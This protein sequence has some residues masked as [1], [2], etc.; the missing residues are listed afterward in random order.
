MVERRKALVLLVEDA[1]MLKGSFFGVLACCKGWKMVI[2]GFRS[3]VLS[4][5]KSL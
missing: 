3:T 2:W 1:L 5:K 4:V